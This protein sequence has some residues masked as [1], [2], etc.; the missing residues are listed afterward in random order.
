MVRKATDADID[1]ILDLLDPYV[2]KDIVLPRTREDI[3]EHL[4]LFLVAVEQNLV[5]GVV[6]YY[7]YSDSLMEIRSLAVREAYFGQGIGSMLVSGIIAKLRGENPAAKIFA[8]T[9]APEF[10]AKRGFEIV[11]SDSLPEKIW[12]DCSKCIKLNCCD[13][14]P[15]VYQGGTD[16]ASL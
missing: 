3:R 4:P 5:A 11:R 14:I 12:K 6:S 15:M 9:L 1:G 7:R 8:L 16:G 2:K 10:F 13:E